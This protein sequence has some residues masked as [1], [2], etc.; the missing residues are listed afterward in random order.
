MIKGAANKRSLSF[1]PMTDG[2][3]PF[4]EALFAS[5]RTE[6]F[7]ASGWPPEVLRQF[8]ADQF[9]LRQRHYRQQYRAAEWLIVDFGGAAIGQL[10]IDETPQRIH[11]IDIALVPAERGE[12][13]GTQILTNLIAS[14]HRKGKSVTA[15]VE[16]TN[17]ALSLYMRLGFEK[18]ED[19]GFYLLTECKA[20]QLS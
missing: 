3:M 10:Y 14:A 5:N 7:A 9:H 6:E 18:I 11:I 20:A 16:R 13:C 15:H 17:R 12:G 8:L 2:D 19:Q 4:A 1:R